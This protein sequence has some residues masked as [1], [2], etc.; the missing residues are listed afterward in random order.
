MQ[1]KPCIAGSLEFLSADPE[2]FAQDQ[3]WLELS[4]ILRASKRCA[5]ASHYPGAHAKNLCLAT[6]ALRRRLLSGS[7]R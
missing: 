4:K 5:A 7:R 1:R 3:E 6:G 2:G